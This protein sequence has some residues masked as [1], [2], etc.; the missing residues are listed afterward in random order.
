MGTGTER[1]GH[2]GEVPQRKSPNWKLAEFFLR[3]MQN[4]SIDTMV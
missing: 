3:F 1:G 4:N 2:G